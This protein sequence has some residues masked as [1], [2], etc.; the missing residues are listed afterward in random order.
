MYLSINKDDSLLLNQNC[1][2][3]ILGHSLKKT[4]ALEKTA[5]TLSR[6]R[7]RLLINKDYSKELYG[8][9]KLSPPDDFNAFRARS[10]NS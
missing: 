3:F 9:Y 6:H 10:R 4:V 1:Y 5:N 8:K 7:R 2:H